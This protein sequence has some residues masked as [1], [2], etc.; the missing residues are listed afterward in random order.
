MANEVLTNPYESIGVLHNQGLDYVIANLG[1]NPTVDDLLNTVADFA[2]IN[3]DNI[4]SP[5]IWQR[6][7]Y[8]EAGA[9]AL[10]SYLC[11]DINRKPQAFSASQATLY[12]RVSDTILNS[13]SRNDIK[14]NLETLEG[15]LIKSDYS[16]KDLQPAL[17]AISVGKHS[18]D[19]W[20]YQ[21][22]NMGASPWTAYL[23]QYPD[24][25]EIAKEIVDTDVE[26]FL[27]TFVVTIILEGGNVITA[28]VTAVVT[29]VVAS[30]A[31]ALWGWIKG[32]FS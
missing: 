8:K 23:N 14:A 29:A 19:Y 10:N 4:S 16:Y 5:T 2:C 12:R 17:I 13:V 20:N 6:A 31:K 18:A 21:I 3:N 9:Y 27:S 1:A 15:D 7:K 11:N 22:D 28:T 32:W 24:L 30:G 25:D 26:T